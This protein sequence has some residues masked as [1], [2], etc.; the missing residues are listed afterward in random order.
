MNFS[1]MWEKW[2][3]WIMVFVCSL[4]AQSARLISWAQI[5][6]VDAHTTASIWRI[7]WTALSQRQ[8][9]HAAWVHHLHHCTLLTSLYSC[10]DVLLFAFIKSIDYVDCCSSLTDLVKVFNFHSMLLH[11]HI[12]TRTHLNHSFRSKC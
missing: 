7:A 11:L 6:T 12:C 8:R 10:V 9:L 3:E 5:S 1:R 2:C 4:H